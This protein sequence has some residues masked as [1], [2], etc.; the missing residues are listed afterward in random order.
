M[1]AENKNVVNYTLGSNRDIQKV[2][3]KNFDKAVEQVR[4]NNFYLKFRGSTPEETAKNVWEYLK[5]NV[6]YKADGYHQKIVL[7]ARLKVGDCKSLSLF[8]AAILYCYYPNNVF[9]RY[10][11]YSD[12]STPT[13]VYTV[14]RIG[15]KEII[16]D[17]VWHTFNSQ[18]NY[19]FKKDVKM[20][21]STLSGIEGL[22]TPELR[23][24]TREL[25]RRLVELRKQT[26]KS[27]SAKRQAIANKIKSLKENLVG[28]EGKKGKGG[29]G[30]KGG[31][32][33]IAL[34]APR[35][36]Y[37][38]LV[39]LNVRGLATRLKKALDKDKAKVQSKWEKLGGKFSSFEKAI[40]V[41]AKKKPFLGAKKIKGLDE[42]LSEDIT[43]G[44]P[45]T[46]TAVGTFLATAAPVIATLG[47]LLSSLKISDKEDNELLDESGNAEPISEDTEITDKEKGGFSPSPLLII[48]GVGVLGLGY[49]LMKK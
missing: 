1:I 47:K 21:I 23:Q 13:H 45:V 2:L 32:K 25:I 48:G 8:A 15:S 46:A 49:F 38:G 42:Y 35:N 7:P 44:E 34:A 11:S 10:V 27:D 36:A 16:I 19:T 31:V 43:I 26:S 3:E 28:I 17:A 9:L 41:G 18:K 40:L 33:K 22:D 5:E 4:Q 20:K 37:L 6:E 39:K 24:G 30:G 14:L 29:K 12:N